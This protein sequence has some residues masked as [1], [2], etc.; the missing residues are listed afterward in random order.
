MFAREIHSNFFHFNANLI[1]VIIFFVKEEKCTIEIE[2]FKLIMIISP[3]FYC[4][5]WC[6]KA[7]F[8]TLIYNGYLLNALTDEPFGE[9]L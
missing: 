8:K 2:F 1:S 4:H 9:F 6:S 3:N 5:F 7:I